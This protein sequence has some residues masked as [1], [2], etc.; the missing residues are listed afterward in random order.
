MLGK[1]TALLGGGL[2]SL[3]ISLVS[4]DS[5][6]A[7]AKLILGTLLTFARAI[8]CM[9]S[10]TAR[11]CRR[12]HASILCRTRGSRLLKAEREGPSHYV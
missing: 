4:P 8:L 11:G 6:F 1:A 10:G 3:L 7:F 2:A 12:R 5:S 9:I